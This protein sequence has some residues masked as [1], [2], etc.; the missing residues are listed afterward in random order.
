LI[1]STSSAHAA[2]EVRTT[3]PKYDDDVDPYPMHANY[4]TMMEDHKKVIDNNLFVAVNMIMAH[5]DKLEGKTTDGNQSGVA[6]TSKQPEFGMPLNFYENQG[7]YVAANKGKLT[8][9][10]FETDEVGLASVAP[11]S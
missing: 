1:T 2:S 9:W 8:P 6:S 5:F 4:A 7:L 10:A 3:K 11:S